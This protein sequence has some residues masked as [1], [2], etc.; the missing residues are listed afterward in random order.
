MNKLFTVTD[1]F[2]GHVNKLKSLK[3]AKIHI[4]FPLCNFPTVCYVTDGQKTKTNSSGNGKRQTE[5]GLTAS[6]R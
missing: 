5:F 4:S 2:T 1:I 6:G 3:A